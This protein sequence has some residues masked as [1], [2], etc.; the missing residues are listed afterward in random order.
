MFY[1]V[2]THYTLHFTVCTY[3]SCIY[4]KVKMTHQ[5]LGLCS[6]AHDLV[7]TVTTTEELEMDK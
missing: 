3:L 7:R 2:G 6:A 1:L 5:K 4:C